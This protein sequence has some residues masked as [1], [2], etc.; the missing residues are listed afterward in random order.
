MKLEEKILYWSASDKPFF[1][2][3]KIEFSQRNLPEDW[4]NE[5]EMVEI[6]GYVNTRVLWKGVVGLPDEVQ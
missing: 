1:L 6:S 5:N 3:D 2:D 4:G